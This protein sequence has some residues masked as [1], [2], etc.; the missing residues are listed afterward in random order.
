MKRFKILFNKYLIISIGLMFINLLFNGCYSLREVNIENNESTIKVYKIETLDGKVIDF[1]DSKLGYA[2]LSNN[3]VV[4]YKPNDEQEVFPMSNIKKYYTE[5]FDTVKTVLLVA[6]CTAA[7]ILIV[8]LLSF[9]VSV[10]ISGI[11]LQ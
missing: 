11:H 2:V 1:Q 7:L 10:P 3:E 8:A 4:S 6:G 5:K 9:K